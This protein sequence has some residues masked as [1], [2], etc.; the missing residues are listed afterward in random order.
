MYTLGTRFLVWYSWNLV[1]VLALMKSCTCLKMG[2]AGSKSRSLGQIIE[3]PMLV[4]SGLQFKSLLPDLNIVQSGRLRWTTLGPSWSSCFAI[5]KVLSI[6]RK[7]Y[8]EG[9]DTEWM[10]N[11]LVRKSFIHADNIDCLVVSN[12]YSLSWTIMLLIG[13][14]R[15]NYSA[16]FYINSINSLPHNPYF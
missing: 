10:K 9:F 16:F 5:W 6:C 11:E 12:K 7:I 2:D 15:Q 4:I 13:T 8:M 3:D 1:K 14:G